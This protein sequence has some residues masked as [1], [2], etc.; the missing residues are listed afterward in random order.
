MKRKGDLI[1]WSISELNTTKEHLADL[2]LERFIPRNDYKTALIKTMK[3][4]TKGNEKLYRRF[5]DLGH[6]VNFSV[7]EQKIEGGDLS[8]DREISISLNKRSGVLT[9]A[10]ESDL[11]KRI[12]DAYLEETKTIDSSQLRSLILK[13]VKHDCFGIPMRQGGG[14]YFIDSRFDEIRT[15][16]TKVFEAF[17]RET[18]IN[19]VPVYSD[20]QTLDAI[21]HAAAEDV[22][23]DIEALVKDINQRFEKGTI[24]R[25]QL[26]GD[27]DRLQE[28]VKKTEVHAE[29]LRTKA[30]A[31]RARLLTAKQAIMKV[32]VNVDA[33][34]IEPADFMKALGKL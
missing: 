12:K 5:N 33:G 27:R 9:C 16:I 29:S 22:F 11:F 21:E 31:I 1:F 3:K 25:R 26:D 10:S 13:I 34:I 23:G 20:A 2:G 18:R 14:I 30:A 8:L 19:T 28:I 7:F 24:T 32:T 17:P 6:N 15:R 4:L